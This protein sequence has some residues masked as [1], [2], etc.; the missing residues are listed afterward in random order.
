VSNS[1]E[2]SARFGKRTARYGLGLLAAGSLLPAAVQAKT[3]EHGTLATANKAAPT[4][5]KT[6][7]T[8][9]LDK[10]A[11][12][13]LDN[14]S[15][16]TKGAMQVI[17]EGKDQVYTA[18]ISAP[19]KYLKRQ[20]SKER[21]EY[22]LSLVAPS[23]KDGSL[24]LKKI[25]SLSLTTGLETS[26]GIFPYS[27]LAANTAVNGGDIIYQTHERQGDKDILSFPSS[28]N[29]TAGSNKLTPSLI[30]D[31]NK[32]GAFMLKSAEKSTPTSDIPATYLP[33]SYA[34]PL[35]LS[36]PDSASANFGN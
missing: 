24:D 31:Y 26:E 5:I 4:N 20:S 1:I 19:D 2:S 28:I 16:Q 27:I 29:P 17:R 3:I 18:T 34:K 10:L 12:T 7:L 21:G 11:N 30:A 32:M 22:I 8:A 13:V 9:M 23:N 35:V 25:K 14:R 36:T 33:F 6:E 15:I